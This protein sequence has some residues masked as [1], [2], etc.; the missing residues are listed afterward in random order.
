M[1]KVYQ[2]SPMP[3]HYIKSK[4]FLKYSRGWSKTSSIPFLPS[5][6]TEPFPDTMTTNRS[7]VRQAGKVPEKGKRKNYIYRDI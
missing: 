1:K 7:K 4:K 6:K 2:K 3:A 5:D